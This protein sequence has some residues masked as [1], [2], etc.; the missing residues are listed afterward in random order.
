MQNHN[1][2]KVVLSIRHPDSDIFTRDWKAVRVQSVPEK[3]SRSVSS[4]YKVQTNNR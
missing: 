4:N 2:S 3:G 1:N